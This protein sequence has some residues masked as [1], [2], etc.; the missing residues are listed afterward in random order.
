MNYAAKQLKSTPCRF[1]IH[2]LVK[3]VDQKTLLVAIISFPM[4]NTCILYYTQKCKR[5]ALT[6]IIS[7]AHY[8]TK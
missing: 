4:Q 1:G 6:P 2:S 3:P 8:T 5:Q 7:T